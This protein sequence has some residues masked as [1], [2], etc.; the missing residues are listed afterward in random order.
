[1]NEGQPLIM[2]VTR[3]R[4]RAEQLNIALDEKYNI[5]EMYSAKEF[6]MMYDI[7]YLKTRVVILDA[8]LPD[9]DM[10]ELIKSLSKKNVMSEYLVISQASNFDES[11]QLLH[12]GVRDIMSWSYENS[13]IKQIVDD[14]VSH[15]D[16]VNRL[17][18]LAHRFFFDH[19]GLELDLSNISEWARK[20]RIEGSYIT[21]NDLLD[22]LPS[23]NKPQEL[24]RDIIKT[25]IL[26]LPEAEK[27]PTILIVED[28]SDARDN[29]KEIIS[30]E[31]SCL[32]AESITEAKAIINS[33]E[34]IDIV[35]LDMHLPGGMGINLI[36]GFKVK[37]ELVEI[38]VVTAF[39]ELDLAI[40]ALKLGAKGYF[41]KP[42][43]PV[44]LHVAISKSAQRLYFKKH[45][46]L[47][48]EHIIQY[49][50]PYKIKL[51]LLNV[52]CER[53]QLKD[54]DVVMSDIYKFFPEL[55]NLQMPDHLVVPS[56]VMED[57]MMVFVEELNE[58][59]S[60]KRVSVDSI[61]TR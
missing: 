30:D 61:V 46:A 18:Y 57:G 47:I 9:T 1:M 34:S 5:M 35:L 49:R 48:E 32:Y 23:D 58:R 50:L 36:D 14:A 26:S 41:N 20:R 53:K 16:S 15:I 45:L 31:F 8:A 22:C 17:K 59:L 37:N 7:M 27:A 21:F 39:K 43:N 52:L 33:E 24:F 29:M 51:Y 25:K 12:N 11:V 2:I 40:K 56:S 60:N 6:L 28:D 19:F 42:Y 13:T 4:D 44:N 3:D 54:Q 55:S 38:I 10:A